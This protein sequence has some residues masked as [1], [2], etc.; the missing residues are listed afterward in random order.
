MAGI[1][2]VTGRKSKV[3][4]GGIGSIVFP[5]QGLGENLRLTFVSF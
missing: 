3:G 1:Y 2:Y 5:L 4:G